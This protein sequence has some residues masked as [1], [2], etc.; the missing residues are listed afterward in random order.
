MKLEYSHYNFPNL[1]TAVCVARKNF[2]LS[3][4]ALPREL[5][6]IPSPVPP[7][8]DDDRVLIHLEGGARLHG[9]GKAR[10][11]RACAGV[12]VAKG[13]GAAGFPLRREGD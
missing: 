6:D 1:N 5:V 3:S 7:A 9:R 8:R 2:S 10:A 12:H 4:N 11:A 13:G